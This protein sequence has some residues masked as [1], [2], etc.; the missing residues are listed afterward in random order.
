MPVPVLGPV[1][2]SDLVEVVFESTLFEQ[3]VL[4]TYHYICI[5]EPA[6]PTDRYAIY[7]EM[8]NWIQIAG[9]LQETFLDMVSDQLTLDSIRIQFRAPE[10]FMY[11]RFTVNL[12]GN[13]TGD[14]NTA[15]IGAS[16]ERRGGEALRTNIGRLAV[17]GIP[18]ASIVAGKITAPALVLLGDHAEVITQDAVL[19]GSAEFSP[20]L[21]TEQPNGAPPIFQTYIYDAAPMTTARTQRRRTVGLGI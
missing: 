19:T 9:G 6:V 14:A 18:S 7:T 2:L 1:Q 8:V 17:A 11:Q 4:N 10:R 3:R 21:W 16:I 5:A 13:L 20:C 12:P 15:N